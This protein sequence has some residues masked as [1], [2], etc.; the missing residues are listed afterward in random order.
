MQ[1][2][3]PVTAARMAMCAMSGTL[4]PTRGIRHSAGRACRWSSGLPLIL[5]ASMLLL[6]SCANRPAATTPVAMAPAS[7][8][9]HARAQGPAVWGAE[10]GLEVLSWI[11]G[12]DAPNTPESPPQTEHDADPSRPAPVR[13][14]IVDS[15]LTI[16]QALAPYI[17]RPVPLSDEMRFRWH[18]AGFRI[19]AVPIADLARIQASLRT[20][21]PTQRQWLG[22]IPRWTDLIRGPAFNSARTLATDAG[23]ARLEAGRLRLL[24]RAWIAPASPAAP[25]LPPPALLRL[26]LVPQHEPHLSDTHRLLA[27]ANNTAP[28]AQGRLFPRLALGMDLR[29]DDALVI[30]PDSPE[31]DW[32]SPPR[33]TEDLLLDSDEGGDAG[34][35]VAEALPALRSPEPARLNWP[36]MGEVMLSAVPTAGSA[37]TRA[38]LVLIPHVPRHFE[39][40]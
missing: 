22:E 7:G 19:V 33:T 12:G 14:T 11:V 8:T 6:P 13:Y 28:E 18:A 1:D 40:R 30:V 24:A 20:V 3:P 16:E 34:G 26:E 25:T 15:R 5:A 29:A 2:Q 37:R 23:P 9:V 36:S 21:G 17:D 39:L 31:S 10:R 27:T 4:H 38:V 35:A 32:G